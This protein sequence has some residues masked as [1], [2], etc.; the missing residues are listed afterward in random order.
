MQERES[1][2]ERARGTWVGMIIRW[3]GLGKMMEGR[4]GGVGAGRGQ[5]REEEGGREARVEE[6][7]ARGEKR[8]GVP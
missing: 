7:R 6:G 2:R 5:E 3:D 1:A 4:D 8:R